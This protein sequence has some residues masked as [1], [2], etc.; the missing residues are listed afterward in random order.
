ME[1]L[2]QLASES[3]INDLVI[4]KTET[5]A[6]QNQEWKDNTPYLTVKGVYDITNPDAGEIFQKKAE[7]IL[8]AKDIES[9][10]EVTP[11]LKGVKFPVIPN[12]I[13]L[14]I[15]AKQSPD[16]KLVT[17]YD[18]WATWCVPCYSL[19]DEHQKLL[20]KHPE[21]SNCLQVIAICI[22]GTKE[23]AR[24]T[25][26]E[27][28][29]SN[30]EHYWVDGG[31]GSTIG[32]MFGIDALPFSI[33]L[34]KAGIIRL[35]GN[36]KLM[37][38]E[39]N[40]Q[41]LLATGSL[42][43]KEPEEEAPGLKDPTYTYDKAKVE[44]AEFVK[45]KQIEM[46]PLKRLVIAVVCVKKYCKD[47]GLVPI[48][49][50]LLLRFNWTFKTQVVAEKIKEDFAKE[51]SNKL[52]LKFQD[53]KI[54]LYTVSFGEKC[55]TCGKILGS[56]NEY[57]CAICDSHFCVLYPTRFCHRLRLGKIWQTYHGYQRRLFP[58]EA[59]LRLRL[60]WSA[61]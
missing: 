45:L 25:I 9:D 37:D 22:D 10:I 61:D 28:V 26:K 35:Y 27:K 14:E 41:S 17:I 34:D 52:M 44:V 1:E 5:Y 50:R 47:K 3:G 19:M 58:K 30:M 13:P 4:T 55:D 11:K 60:L 59:Q 43:S 51:F 15:G 42:Y 48:N 20:E 8:Q 24:E 33:L 39:K 12:M 54:E 38:L 18:F 21:W 6:Y 31:L 29:W 56:C 49:L 36:P 16:K 2:T 46:T 53:R 57:Q 32:K 23:K 40:V 7:E